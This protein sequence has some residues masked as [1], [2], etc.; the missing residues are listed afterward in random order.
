MR[1]G[2]GTPSHCAMGSPPWVGRKIDSI[3]ILGAL[4]ALGLSWGRLGPS[5]GRLGVQLGPQDGAKMVKKS[6]QKPIKNLMHLK[7]DFWSDFNGFGDGK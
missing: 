5:W 2:E 6:M 7:I 4:V 1:P 3:L